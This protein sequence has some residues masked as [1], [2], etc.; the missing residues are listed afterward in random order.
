M[1]TTIMRYIY[2]SQ[3]EHRSVSEV[4]LSMVV[5]NTNKEGWDGYDAK[6]VTEETINTALNLIKSFVSGIDIGICNDGSID[7]VIGGYIVHKQ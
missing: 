4:I 2:R 6:P 7:L 5:Q 1:Q 3:Y